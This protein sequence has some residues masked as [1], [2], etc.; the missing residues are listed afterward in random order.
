MQF[1]GN[2]QHTNA[3]GNSYKPYSDGIDCFV[4]YSH[5]IERLFLV[6]EDEVDANMSI[7]VETPKQR[8]EDMNWAADYAFDERWPP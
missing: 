3:D 7:R 1:K 8:H 4:V 6:W 2:S 5:D